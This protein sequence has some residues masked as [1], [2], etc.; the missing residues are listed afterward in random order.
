MEPRPPMPW[1]NLHAMS[2]RERRAIYRYVPAAGPAGRPMSTA[3]PPGQAPAPPFVQFP[4]EVKAA[5]RRRAAATNG[6]AR[7]AACR[8]REPVGAGRLVQRPRPRKTAS[9]I[10]RPAASSSTDGGSGTTSTL[11]SGKRASNAGRSATR[12]SSSTIRPK[13]GA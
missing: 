3:L 8:T 11:V 10:A 2:E 12:P 7:A 6:T 5:R 13:L 9:S 4:D 1:W